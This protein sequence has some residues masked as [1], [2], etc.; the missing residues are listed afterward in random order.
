MPTLPPFFS[1]V[2]GINRMRN[3]FEIGVSAFE[4][5]NAAVN[6]VVGGDQTDGVD[7]FLP[8]PGSALDGVS[9]GVFGFLS[10]DNSVVILFRI[11]A[12]TL[13]DVV[14]GNMPADAGNEKHIRLTGV[15]DFNR[16]GNAVAAAGKSNDRRGVCGV[17][18]FIVVDAVGKNNKAGKP[19][20]NDKQGGDEQ[21][22]F[23]H[24]IFCRVFLTV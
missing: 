8:Q 11:D 15:K 17:V 21:N 24:N 3:D 13:F 14:K 23:Y 7:V 20:N 9:F 10:D 16:F 12:L 1:D 2:F 6:M 22:L 18:K 19:G 4:L 5:G